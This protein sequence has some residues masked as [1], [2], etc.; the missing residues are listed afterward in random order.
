M[1]ISLL[2]YSLFYSTINLTNQTK[3]NGGI[4]M[5]SINQIAQEHIQKIKEEMEYNKK[6]FNKSMKDYTIYSLIEIWE[7]EKT[8]R[9]ITTIENNNGDV[10]DT[11]LAT[12][13]NDISTLNELDEELRN[14]MQNETEILNVWEQANTPTP[15]YN[16]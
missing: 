2:T 9:Y 12:I 5:K 14:L 1:Q 10:Y 7:D 16:C 4:K 8:C 15:T 6:S 11:L 13:Q 3:S